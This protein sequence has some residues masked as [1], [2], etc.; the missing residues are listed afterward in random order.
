MLCRL[1]EGPRVRLVQVPVCV[2]MRRW[3]ILDQQ[4]GIIAVFDQ[5]AEDRFESL[6]VAPQRC[7]VVQWIGDS[8][9]RGQQ[10]F[11]FRTGAGGRRL[12]VDVAL[13]PAVCEYRNI[14][15][16]AGK[17]RKPSSFRCARNRQQVKRFQHQARRAHADH[18]QPV[19]QGLVE[20]V[21]SGH[22]PG[23]CECGPCRKVRA[24]DLEDHQRYVSIQG[25]KSCFDK[26]RN[27]AKRFQIDAEGGD[28]R[29]IKKCFQVVLHTQ[30]R[31]IARAD[32]VGKVD[33][34]PVGEEI[35]GQHAGL[36]NNR[37]S[38]GH[39]LAA[40]AVGPQMCALHIVEHT[41]DVRSDQ[42]K[43]T[44]RFNQC[45]LQGG[46]FG[47]QFPESGAITN[48]SAGT[49]LVELPDDI[50]YSR[51]GDCE[52]YSIRCFR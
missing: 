3:I 2:Q 16:G 21:V 23:V 6:L 52:E 39:T 47:S 17:G 24:S 8:R 10:V 4:R 27:V 30:N 31:L 35:A 33:R 20:G 13:D 32:H 12:E 7:G 46:T 50:G 9:N 28:F 15:S 22:R 29:S 26:L 48:H 49:A 43:I 42:S 38:T 25:L 18:A 37:R 5:G 45:L 36:G 41:E 11:E 51:R 14:T 1:D 40:V 19:E 44:R 34:S